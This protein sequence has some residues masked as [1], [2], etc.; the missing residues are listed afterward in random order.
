MQVECTELRCARGGS[1]DHSCWRQLSLKLPSEAHHRQGGYCTNQEVTVTVRSFDLVPISTETDQQTR[2]KP[3]IMTIH[4]AQ[5][6]T[7]PRHCRGSMRTVAYQVCKETLYARA[8]RCGCCGDR[9]PACL[10]VRCLDGRH[11]IPVASSIPQVVVFLTR[12]SV[13]RGVSSLLQLYVCAH[14]CG[15][16]GDRLPASPAPEQPTTSQSRAPSTARRQ[17]H[18]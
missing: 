13:D 11:L 5:A 10:S 7:L 14:R 3:T 2:R 9:P 15:C 17:S 6:I 8:Q 16:C 12:T 1:S 18:L 4:T